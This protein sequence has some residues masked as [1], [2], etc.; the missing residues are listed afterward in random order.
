MYSWCQRCCGVRWWNWSG[1]PISSDCTFRRCAQRLSASQRFS[2]I[3]YYPKLAPPPCVL[4]AFRHHSGSHAMVA[5]VVQSDSTRAQRLSASQR[6]SPATLVKKP[7]WV[8]GCS[9]PF[10]ITAVLTWSL[11]GWAGDQSGAQRLSASQRFSPQVQLPQDD[12][13]DVLNA[14]RHHSGSHQKH[15]SR[16]PPGDCVLNAFRHHSGSHKATSHNF[17][18]LI[19]CS[20]PFGITAVLTA[21]S[22]FGVAPSAIVLN[23]FRHHSGSHFC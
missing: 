15:L 10:G 17:T 4:N 16:Y 13:T 12:T 7:E 1:A 6:F 14:F 18:T 2:L 22:S 23:A 19:S 9:T 11:S 5:S 20:T 21:A 8:Q 3:N